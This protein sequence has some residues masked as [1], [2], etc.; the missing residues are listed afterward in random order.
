MYSIGMLMEESTEVSLYCLCLGQMNACLP[1][2]TVWLWHNAV[3]GKL[4]VVDHVLKQRRVRADFIS[5]SD[6]LLR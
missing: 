6:R 2:F 1:M 5:L 4:D 3:M